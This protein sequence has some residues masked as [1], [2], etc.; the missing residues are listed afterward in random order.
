VSTAQDKVVDTMPLYVIFTSGSSGIPKGVTTSHHAVMSYLEDVIHIMGIHSKDV[1][2]NQSPMDYIAAVRDIYIPIITG[3]TTVI[4]P[5]NI[6]SIPDNLRRVLNNNKVTTICW[7]ASGLEMC[8]RVGLFECGT[9]EYVDKILF[10]GSVLS[11]KALM[12]W[13]QALPNA[14]MVNQYGPTEATASCTYYV[15][16]GKATENTILP[17][18]KPFGN[19]KIILLDENNKETINNEIGEICVSGSIVSLG[20]YKNEGATKKAFIQNPLNSSYREI[21]YR[22]GDYGRYNNDGLLEYCGRIDRQIKLLGHRIELEEL[23]AIGKSI[24]GVDECISIFDKIKETLYFVYVGDASPRDISLFFRKRIPSYMIPRKII[25]A[26]K[27]EK[28]PNGKIDIK[29]NE[30]KFIQ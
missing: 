13:Q 27:L 1:L 17:I 8:N 15:V 10:S 11:S 12:A 21:I 14:K 25:Q 30:R 5:S 3:A 22:T 9:L 6:F 28:L 19:Y 2:G 26:D 24:A 7:S 29:S 18:G 23:E 4:I 20:Y 16:K